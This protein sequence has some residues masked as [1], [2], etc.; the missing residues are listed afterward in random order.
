[1]NNELQKA[2]STSISISYSSNLTYF[3]ILLFSKSNLKVIYLVS[4]WRNKHSMYAIINSNADITMVVIYHL[5]EMFCANCFTMIGAYK[6]GQIHPKSWR[7][8]SNPWPL[9]LLQ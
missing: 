6:H 4:G 3:F 8:V 7:W 2:K 5:G 1:M 9:H